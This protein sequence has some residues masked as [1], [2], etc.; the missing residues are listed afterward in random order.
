MEATLARVEAE[1]EATL[2]A[3]RREAEAMLEAQRSE[4]EAMLEAQRDELVTR[5]TQSRGSHYIRLKPRRL[6][7]RSWPLQCGS[8]GAS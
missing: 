2:E 8:N 3:R 1:A 6:R 5:R 7:P 4:A